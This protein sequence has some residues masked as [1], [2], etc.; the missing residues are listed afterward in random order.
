M[1]D[2]LLDKRKHVLWL[3]WLL[4]VAIAY[5]LYFNESTQI[6]N[7][8]AVLAL[9]L[10][11]GSLN[12]G[13]FFLPARLFDRAAFD[14]TLVF[15]N[16]GMVSLAIYLSGQEISDFY[17]FFF[18]ILMMAAA[19][20]NLKTFVF[21]TLTATGLYLL[22]VYRTG[23]FALTS[24]FLLRI[25]FLFIVGLFFGY[26]VYLQKVGRERL[27]AESEFTADLFS[28]GKTLTLAEDLENL[29]TKIPRLIK[30][31]MGTD[32]CELAIIEDNQ[33]TRRMFQ[34][35]DKKEY[36]AVEVSQSIHETTCRSPEIHTAVLDD[37]PQLLT[38]ED[39][40]L[41]SH[42]LYMGRCW[43]LNGQ[44]SGLI[45]VYRRGKSKW[46]AH[47]E[48]KF[49]FLTDQTALSIEHLQIL[50]QLES[51]ARTDGLTGLANYR[52]FTERVEEEF[53]RSRRLANPLSLVLLDI[54]RFK[55]INDTAG[56]AV[57]DQI[58][59][60]L[61]QVLMSNSRPMDLPGRCGG[62]EFA[63]LLPETESDEARDFCE[64]LVT[65]VKNLDSKGKTPG[66]SISVGSSTFPKHSL[67]IAELFS[68]ADEALYLAKSQGRGCTRH[69]SEVMEVS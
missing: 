13:L 62:D 15:L 16:I 2:I 20:Q 28:F 35:E 52:Y 38:K 18:V 36:P 60:R 23:N 26:L 43:W 30:E 59:R 45:A 61:A 63:V 3:Q 44:L 22:M 1:T 67:T 55:D 25:P 34:D 56:H 42:P 46:T 8:A 47:D 40:G 53:S 31:I 54:D 51:Q 66:F 17:L 27:Q 57:G 64:R 65:S 39:I 33:V 48:K 19:G 21:G 68:H 4:V 10:L 5:L 50:K 41:Y 12:V 9:I 24:G 37:N 69:Y 14:Y 29:Y 7:P 32:S 6:P 11:N 49:Q 58:L